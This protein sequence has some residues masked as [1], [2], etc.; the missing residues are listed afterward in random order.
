MATLLRTEENDTKALVSDVAAIGFG[1]RTKGS[2]DNS[3]KA[4]TAIFG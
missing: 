1:A 3:A 2:P 4:S